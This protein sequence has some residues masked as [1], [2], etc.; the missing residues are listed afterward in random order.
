MR[1]LRFVA[2]LGTSL[3]A[4]TSPDA[5]PRAAA[6]LTI[7]VVARGDLL[8]EDRSVNEIVLEL[9]TERLINTA[10]D[11]RA[12]PGLATDFAI[13]EDGLDV[14]L[15]LRPG[16]TFHDG[17]MLAAEGVREFL[18]T[19]RRDPVAL[20]QYPTL[21]DIRTIQVVD[22]SAVRVQFDHPARF[23]LDGL[24]L[25]LERQVDDRPVGT[26]PFRV[27][28]Q[29]AE[30][31]VLVPHPD[32][33]LGTSAISRIE[34]S[35]F[36][37]LRAAWA[38][39]LRGEVDFLFQVP[40]GSRDF[41]EA[42]SGV[43]LFRTDSPYAHMIGLNAG[44]P[45]FRD[46]R[47]RQALNYAIDRR[48]VSEQAF[49]GEGTPASGVW[50]THWVYGSVD[51]VYPY[52]PLRADELLREAGYSKSDQSADAQRRLPSRLHFTCL[53]LAGDELQEL[54]ALVV[55]RQLSELGVD[56]EL[57]AMDIRGMQQRVQVG[58]YDAVL[59]PQLTGRVLS[60]LYTFWH[61]SEPFA[62]PG[63]TA[64]DEHLDALRLASTDADL[65][66]AAR[67]I[68]RTLYEDP[69]GIFLVNLTTARA[70]SRRFAV[71]SPVERDVAQTVW[72]WQPTPIAR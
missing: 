42:E 9:T 46:R 27:E 26:G 60:R 66:A 17:E 68:Q 18:D 30:R 23:Q 39:M 71:P 59:R 40:I 11:G 14:T 20:Q 21:R 25:R 15:H 47:V 29:T 67:R 54:T 16:V 44:G 57:E 5:P 35:P 65:S 41:V 53:V 58:E 62:L 43:E 48:A 3:V 63:Y 19:T 12:E 10:S 64:I 49:G 13:S 51:R 2:L 22:E 28:T 61:S 34:I 72:Q 24:K 56:M 6:T 50:A 69:P 7:G 33:H 52:D 70:V 31:V 36:P 32:Y 1:V 55:Q 37:T 4:C 8:V 38:S 45:K